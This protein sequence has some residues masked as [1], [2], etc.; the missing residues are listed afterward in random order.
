[1]RRLA[2]AIALFFWSALVAAGWFPLAVSNPQAFFAAVGSDANPCTVTQ[3]CLTITKANTLTA[4]T[5]ARFRGGDT[6]STT[7][8][9]T[10]NISAT[11][12]GT[13]QATISSGN[14]AQCIFQTN[15]SLA[16]NISNIICTGGGVAS[17]TT[18]GIL[19]SNTSSATNL[20]GPTITNVTLSGYGGNG[21]Y[22]FSSNASCGGFSNTTISNNTINNVTGTVTSPGTAAINFKSVVCYGSGAQSPVF[23]GATINSNVISNIP[24][25]ANTSSYSGTGISIGEASGVTANSNTI[26]NLGANANHCGGASAV[27][28]I[29][30]INVTS[31]SNSIY[32]INYASGGCDG[33]GFDISDN[34]INATVLYNYVSNPADHCFL[35]TNYADT[36]HA[37]ANI[38]VGFNVCQNP[39]YHSA[40]AFDIQVNATGA[41]NVYNNTIVSQIP[42]NGGALVGNASTNLGTTTATIANN[43]FIGNANDII[44]L[45][46]PSSI[47]FYGND[48]Y[49]YGQGFNVSW[50]GTTYTSYAAW[51]TA[52]GQEKISGSNVGLT[53]NPSIYVPGGG[54]DIPV[55]STVAQLYAYYLQ[56]GSPMA[57]AG[58]NLQTQFGINPGTQDFY[59]VSVSAASLPVGASAGDFGTFTASCTASTNFLARVSSFTKAQNVNY[60]S[61]LCHLN[62]TGDLALMDGLWVHGAPNSAASLLNLIS[63]SFSLTASGTITFTANVGVQGNGSTGVYNT[64]FNPTSGSPNYAL[65][66]TAVAS[67][68]IT[69]R[70]TAA[71]TGTVGAVNSLGNSG[72]TL[73]LPYDTGVNAA[74]GAVNEDNTGLVPSPA[75]ATAKGLHIVLRSGASSPYQ[76]WINGVLLNSPSVASIAVPN[77]NFSILALTGSGG[78]AVDFS[79]DQVAITA[80]GA[81]FNPT[82]VSQ[83][84]NSFEAAN[85]QNVY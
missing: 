28:I 21:V 38:N 73:I 26:S 67:Y 13:G 20:P 52:T 61:L 23:V 48:Y 76:Y 37:F 66:S 6:F 29:D 55:G 51:Q 22:I 47:N 19:F 17:N 82:N 68:V 63:T 74:Y 1:M 70:T 64:G 83:I 3:P 5:I 75:N 43:I 18:D 45:T 56:S 62:S 25:A 7:T 79:T 57:G 11:S 58:I 30:S 14:S 4:G 80:I 85:G 49:T 81:A 60:N 32:D 42:T 27:L 15:P 10:A 8:G 72:D 31:N 9:I 59:G 65:N 2:A 77:Q 24:G 35:M 16:V 53:S 54:W 40:V 33:N 44:F 34:V 46:V 12:Y 71:H 84:F 50:N 41:I 36:N 78:S 69:N 39:K